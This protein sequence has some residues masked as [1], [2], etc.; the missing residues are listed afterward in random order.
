MI[1]LVLLRMCQKCS[2]RIVLCRWIAFEVN[3]CSLVEGTNLLDKCT[4]VILPVGGLCYAFNSVTMDICF[5]L[6]IF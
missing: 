2:F 1:S 6:V 5:L 3:V 4:C